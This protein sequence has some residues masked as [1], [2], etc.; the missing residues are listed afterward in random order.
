M[1]FEASGQDGG[2]TTPF[3]RTIRPVGEWPALQWKTLILRLQLEARILLDEATLPRD[4]STDSGGNDG[5]LL[6]KL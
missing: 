3:D 5:R 4:T 2:K 1:A 6:T